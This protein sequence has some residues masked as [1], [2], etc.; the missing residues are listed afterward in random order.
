MDRSGILKLIQRSALPGDIRE[1]LARVV[2]GGSGS[3]LKAALKEDPAALLKNMDR[4]LGEASG[5]LGCSKEEALFIT[6]FNKNDLAPERFEAALAEIRAVVFLNREGFS[7]LRFISRDTGT[8]ADI[9]GRKN[10]QNYVFEV[11]C[12]QA[13]KDLNAEYLELKYD[14]KRRQ[15]NS[16]RKK[17]KCAFGGLIFAVR[18]SDFKGFADEEAL[19]NIA[20][21][22]HERKN[23][24]GNTHVCILSGNSGVAFPKWRRLKAS[25]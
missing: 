10:E 1:Y 21:E 25:V 13:D 4:L 12:C 19:K 18:P 11:C 22:L 20:G 15:V 6:G 24:P 5:I 23:K 17:Q 7:A 2:G 3:S 8:S 14:K 9:F 16:S